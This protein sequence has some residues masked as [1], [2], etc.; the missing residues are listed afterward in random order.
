MTSLLDGKVADGFLKNNQDFGQ[1]L[2]KSYALNAIY[3]DQLHLMGDGLSI[4][5]RDEMM[6]GIP[7]QSDCWW[8]AQIQ[9]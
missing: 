9:I 1:A 3:R 6:Q 5:E 8:E 4:N 2:S 7:M